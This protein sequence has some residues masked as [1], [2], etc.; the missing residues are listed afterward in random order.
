MNITLDDKKIKKIVYELEDGNLATY[1]FKNGELYG[2]CVS[3]N[4]YG[5]EIN[6][7]PEKPGL[8]D[9]EMIEKLRNSEFMNELEEAKKRFKLGKEIADSFPDKDDDGN[10]KQPDRKYSDESLKVAKEIIEMDK[11]GK[12]DE[13]IKRRGSGSIDKYIVQELESP[14]TSE[15]DYDAS[16]CSK[17]MN[18][19]EQKLLTRLRMTDNDVTKDESFEKLLENYNFYKTKKKEIDDKI[20]AQ[21]PKAQ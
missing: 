16:A 19:I 18:L 1:N 15:L 10:T 12:L 7:M 8:S 3:S 13:I 20:W 5:T 11:E 14:F 6:E 21:V 4:D 9:S 2:V 17:N